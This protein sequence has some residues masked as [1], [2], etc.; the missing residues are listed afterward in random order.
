MN[1]GFYGHSIAAR[2]FPCDF[3]YIELFEKQEDVNVVHVGCS[4]CSEER[5]LFDL[6]KTDNLDLAVI[7]HAS[8]LSMFVPSLERDFSTLD[9]DE[10]YRKLN[11][12]TAKKVQ[13]FFELAEFSEEEL[14]LLKQIPNMAAFEIV[15]ANRPEVPISQ[16]EINALAD[17]NTGDSSKFKELIRLYDKNIDFSFYSELFDALEL[18]KKY[19]HNA[20][21]QRNRY[22]GALIQIDQY[23][24]SRNIPTIHCLGKASWYPNWFKFNSGIVEK[25]LYKIQETKEYK[26]S[27]SICD[28][29][30]NEEANKIIFDKLNVLIKQLCG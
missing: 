8:P 11:T 9:R 19:L 26:I 1:I 17:W 18:Y 13:D 21:L 7:W 27:Y 23:V 2:S 24:T 28:N 6:K 14:E 3:N 25:E 16:D 22:Y 15:T 20:D 5:I 10:L 12:L 4:Q 29:G 30:M